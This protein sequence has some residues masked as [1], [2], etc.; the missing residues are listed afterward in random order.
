MGASFVL[1]MIGIFMEQ[2]E[3][4]K[5][6]ESLISTILISA[7]TSMM[8]PLL[9]LWTAELFPTKIRG[10]ASA[11][12]LFVGKLFGGLAPLLSNLCD[13]FGIHVLVGCSAIGLFSLIATSYLDE[14]Y[15]PNECS[16][17]S[18]RYRI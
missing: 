11:V 9:F 6:I 4:R 18:N 10:L 12:I 14:T 16:S 15:N 1:L 2:S 8:F 3:M 13:K 7:V 5:W 17:S